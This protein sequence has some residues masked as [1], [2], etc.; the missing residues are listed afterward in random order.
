MASEK[1]VYV[2]GIFMAIVAL[3]MSMLIV[4]IP[5]G[6]G[7]IEI[8]SV[9]MWGICS[10]VNLVFGLNTKIKDGFFFILSIIITVVFG[11]VVFIAEKMLVHT[12]IL[13][14]GALPAATLALA[15]LVRS[16]KLRNKKNTK[17][18]LILNLIVLIIA[19][20][21]EIAGY[22]VYGGLLVGV[23]L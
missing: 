14:L 8:A 10:I 21:V 18:A 11:V 16:I 15:G 1:R 23:D 3:T 2:L 22:V 12:D 13:M 20:G 9:A 4:G 5:F 7:A 6:T 19:I 17:A